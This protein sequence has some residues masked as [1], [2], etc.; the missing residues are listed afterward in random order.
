VLK[1]EDGIDG[2]RCQDFGGILIHEVVATF[3]GVEHVPFPVI[4]LG[5]SQC[6]TDPALGRSGMRARGIELADDRD[7]GL[8][9]ELNSS[10]QAGTTRANNDRIVPVIRHP[11]SPSEP[12][13]QAAGQS[14]G[15]RCRDADLR[16]R[17]RPF[18]LETYYS[19]FGLKLPGIDSTIGLAKDGFRLSYT[20]G[21]YC[22]R[23]KLFGLE[24]DAEGQ[25]YSLPT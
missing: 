16:L 25:D 5:V 24:F 9:G 19:T 14:D 11:V 6:G 1:F 7:V 22:H 4:F 10:H 15:C 8:P 21:Q 20:F 12:H 17:N 13:N 18:D 3:D 2:F 23:G